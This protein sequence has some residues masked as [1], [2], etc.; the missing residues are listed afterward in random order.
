MATKK[1][2]KIVEINNC[3]FND[4]CDDSRANLITAVQMCKKHD[5]RMCVSSD[6]HF[7][8]MVGDFELVCDFLTEMEIP[9]ELILNY[10]IEA[11][12]AYIKEK[13]RIKKNIRK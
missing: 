12:D 2:N 6:S 9:S 13:K 8:L 1:H 4:H 3:S 11:F 5:V 7:H 10:D